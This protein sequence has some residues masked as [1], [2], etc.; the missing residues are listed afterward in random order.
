M[1]MIMFPNYFDKKG[2]RGQK[3]LCNSGAFT[4]DSPMCAASRNAAWLLCYGDIFHDRVPF[5]LDY[6]N[7][8]VIN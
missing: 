2:I 6:V 5:F 7:S 3:T 8:R 1:M 4:Q